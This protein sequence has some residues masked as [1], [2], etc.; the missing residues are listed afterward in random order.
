[1]QIVGTIVRCRH[2]HGLL[3]EVGMKFEHRIDP[4][5]FINPGDSPGTRQPATI[6]LP[7][8]LGRVA[9]L[10]SSK[11]EAALLQHHLKMGG[12]NP[13]MLHTSGAALDLVKK[14]G[15]DI[16]LT[17]LNIAGHDGVEFIR[18]LR[19]LKF[20]GPICVITAEMDES[21]LNQARRVGAD[22]ILAKPYDSPELIALLIQ[23]NERM[24]T[25][26]ARTAIFSSIDEQAGMTNIVAGFIA[27]T[28]Q[29]AREIESA[30]G[31]GD[32]RRLRELLLSL[33]G[34]A[35]GYGF[36]PLGDLARQ[37]LELM[38]SQ[39]DAMAINPRVRVICSLCRRLR[40]RRPQGSGREKSRAA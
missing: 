18:K 11:V 12:V 4:T 27:Q 31:H 14:C 3:H 2:V 8:L 17:E 34:S 37:A 1:M 20:S 39:R 19:E 40:M 26:L 22:H 30:A 32:A 38:D 21:R 7:E 35:P 24:G 5:L 28:H 16:F 13:L 23:M 15:A 6:E 33:K 9:A 10:E 29:T 36:V 25:A